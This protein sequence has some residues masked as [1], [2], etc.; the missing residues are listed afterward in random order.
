M[1]YMVNWPTIRGWPWACFSETGSVTGDHYSIGGKSDGIFL[2][3]IIASMKRGIY[4]E[5]GHKIPVFPCEDNGYGWLEGKRQNCTT[6]RR[7]FAPKRARGN[8]KGLKSITEQN[9]YKGKVDWEA[10]RQN[11]TNCL[12]EGL[13]L[14][15]V[16]RRL[17]VSPSTLSEANKRYNLYPPQKRVA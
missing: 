8:P 12:S 2:A 17:G 5:K 4:T 3:N 15:D 14:G 10:D 16:A 11:I 6:L 13:S 1:K 7:M 9:R